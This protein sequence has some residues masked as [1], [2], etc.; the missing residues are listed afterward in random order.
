M[1]NEVLCALRPV[2]NLIETAGTVVCAT[3]PETSPLDN[4]PY[5]TSAFCKIADKVTDELTKAAEDMD[6]NHM[7]YLDNL[8]VSSN[9]AQHGEV[10]ENKE[11]EANGD[12]D[13]NGVEP[14]TRKRRRGVLIF[15][16]EDSEEAIADSI[17]QHSGIAAPRGALK[18]RKMND[19]RIIA[20]CFCLKSH[21]THPMVRRHAPGEFRL[22]VAPFNLLTHLKKN[23]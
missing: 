7:L 11:I 12:F 3:S 5:N 2:Q 10:E 16:K 13:A 1:K 6:P 14:N 23:H 9:Q 20:T 17:L 4:L 19:A 21:G 15:N 22:N 8:D 18:V